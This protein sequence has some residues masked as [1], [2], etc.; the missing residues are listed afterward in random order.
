MTVN[1]TAGGRSTPDGPRQPLYVLETRLVWNIA[2]TGSRCSTTSC[3]IRADFSFQP[4]ADVNLDI[5]SLKDFTYNMATFS[6]TRSVL[7]I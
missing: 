5:I 2:H 3:V 1:F 7:G 4:T 6:H